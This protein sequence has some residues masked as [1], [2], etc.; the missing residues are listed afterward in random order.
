MVTL[1]ICIPT[2]NRPERVAALLRSLA[3]LPRDVV[4]LEVLVGDN[5][6]TTDT[7]VVC[8]EHP[9]VSYLRN[10]GDLG[11][12]GN[13]NSLVARARG[14]WVHL[15]ADDD[16][17]DPGYLA[18][19]AEA[20]QDPEAVLVTGRVGFIGDDAVQVEAAHYAR[21][22]RMGID[23]PMRLP[24]DAV[25]NG[26]LIHGCPFEFS[27]TLMRRD[28]VIAAG[29]FDARFRLQ[30]D[31]E[32]WLRLLGLGAAHFVDADLGAFRVYEGNMLGDRE[33]ARAFRIERTLIRLAEIAR[34]VHLLEPEI[35]RTIVREIRMEL[36][37]VRTFARIGI[38]GPLTDGMISLGL[39][40]AEA[41]LR[42]R[43][44]GAGLQLPLVG[45][46]PESPRSVLRAL[47]VVVDA[48]RGDERLGGSA[49]DIG[50][51]RPLVQPVAG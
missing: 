31:Y 12:Y 2:R 21:L 15:V 30:G 35:R 29:G 13:F 40:Q 25:I 51:R 18:G 45:L 46:I 3:D 41:A 36:P 37:R 4:D 8:A 9:D 24:G 26:A 47:V 17:V 14:D 22:T 16:E 33:S 27:H 23:F 28:A 42:S 43:G 48:L 10:A 34:H 1:S 7:Q 32:L 5:S 19:V 11:A 49:D 44:Y 39:L 6:T 38:G 20:L 50:T